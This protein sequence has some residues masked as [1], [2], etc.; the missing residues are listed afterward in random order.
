MSADGQGVDH[1]RHRRKIRLAYAQEG[2][3]MVE[4]QL[5]GIVIYDEEMCVP[6]RQLQ[7]TGK[8]RIDVL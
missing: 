2:R 8:G 4:S 6:V 7:P 5:I 3:V 1:R